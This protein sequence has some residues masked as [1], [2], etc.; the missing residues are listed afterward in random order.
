MADE[1]V[2]RAEGQDCLFSFI[3]PLLDMYAVTSARVKSERGR[4]NVC[5]SIDHQSHNGRSHT[6]A[7]NGVGPSKRRGLIK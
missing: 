7:R 4:D 1:G 2:A 3:D 6:L 5:G